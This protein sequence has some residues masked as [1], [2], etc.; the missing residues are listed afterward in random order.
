MFSATEYPATTDKAS[1]LNHHDPRVQNLLSSFVSMLQIWDLQRPKIRRTPTQAK[2]T[3]Q[4][5]SARAN[6]TFH[7]ECEK[8]FRGE[9]IKRARVQGPQSRIQ[10]ER[11][12]THL[13]TDDHIAQSGRW[14]LFYDSHILAQK[15]L[16]F[17]CLYRLSCWK[18]TLRKTPILTTAFAAST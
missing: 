15:A 4:T 16:V 12:L 13:C 17:P 5:E 2:V 1:F 9:K 14:F 3:W 8:Q 7:P 11:I 10:M 18:P 6:P